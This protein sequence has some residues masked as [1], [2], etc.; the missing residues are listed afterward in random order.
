MDFSSYD[1]AGPDPNP[2]T[3]AEVDALKELVSMLPTNPII[4]NI[5]AE[6]GTSTLAM[7]EERPDA[8]IFSIDTGQC[9]QEFSNLSKALLDTKKVVRILGRS[10][11]IG[12]LWPYEVHL[13]FVDGDHS[14]Q[15]VSGDIFA[16]RDKIVKN[17]IFAFHDYIPEPIPAHIK[18]RVHVAVDSLMQAYDRIMLV[19]RLIAFKV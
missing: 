19:D 6:R 14:A 9:Q 7:L 16:W 1:L 12:D 17:G 5:G 15:G 2:M 10:Q 4:V 13:V 8:F 3:V 18:G 11:E